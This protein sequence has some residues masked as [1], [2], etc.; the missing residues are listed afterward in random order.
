[1]AVSLKLADAFVDV[2]A[3][4]TRLAGD[5]T[6]VR[7]MLAG[8]GAGGGLAAS[9]V[10]GIAPVGAAVEQA[11][12]TGMA[13]GVAQGAAKAPA[14]MVGLA[15]LQMSGIKLQTDLAAAAAKAQQQAT[16]SAARAP[17]GMVGLNKL[18]MSGIA[19]QDRLTRAREVAA[20]A[21]EKADARSAA[22]AAKAAA[23]A[24]E[25][26]VG[27]GRLQMSGIALQDRL[28]RAREQ[29]DR[30]AA[31]GPAGMVGLEKLQMSGIA[32]QDKLARA[33]EQATAGAAADARRAAADQE[34]DATR[35]DAIQERYLKR[36]YDRRVRY[37]A[38]KQ[39]AVDRSLA[40]MGEGP[41]VERAGLGLGRFL[42][43]GGE[44]GGT[45][46][47]RERGGGFLGGMGQVAGGMLMARGMEAALSAPVR[48]GEAMFDA[49]K[50]ASDLGESVSK[51]NVSFGPAAKDVVGQADML[52]ER[53]GVV[54]RESLDAAA[55]FG[56]MGQAAGQTK[57]ESAAMGNRFVRMG[58][59]I[60]SFH[61]IA[62]AEAFEKL[63]SGLA[64]E[65]E[66]LRQIGILLS[67]DAVQAQ[68][69][70][71]G[72][73]GSASEAKHLTQQQKVSA[74]VELIAAQMGPAM[75]DLERTAG[76][77]A[78][79]LR[80]L[81]GDMENLTT[82]F[83]NELQDALRAGLGLARDLGKA[84]ADA[85]GKGAPKAVGEV[86]KATVDATRTVVQ[87]EG[88]GILTRLNLG[89]AQALSAAF[90]KMGLGENF[91]RVK[92]AADAMQRE[93]E[94]GTAA[95]AGMKLA[96]GPATPEEQVAAMEKS[97]VPAQM[98]RA[99][100]SRAVAAAMA[101]AATEGTPTLVGPPRPIGLGLE[102]PGVGLAREQD[103]IQAEM[104]RREREEAISG[105]MLA[106]GAALARPGAIP[107]VSDFRKK[108]M[109]PGEL[110]EVERRKAM[111]FIARP[112]EETERR[113]SQMF[114]DPADYATHAIQAALSA[115]DDSP[116]QTAEATKRGAVLLQT[117]VD[118]IVPVTKITP[119]LPNS[120]S[121]V[122]TKP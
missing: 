87:G 106:R 25:G 71:M 75:G 13:R 15:K 120:G 30:E 91:G 40:Q 103:R 50:K 48:I 56:L 98:E 115:K 3:D 24:P 55:A 68:A 61:N 57:E 19:L 95:A 11:V 21:Q 114:T 65:I 109:E 105:P 63:R 121:F 100:Q 81:Q 122:F 84:I 1:M 99:A 117:L 27:L 83:G 46:A 4:L 92:E 64:G 111:E 110:A 12:A 51:V 26:M 72:L 96:A 77:A 104:L 94:G 47:G 62:N 23:R 60:A 35:L 7:S 2:R 16:A 59:D 85:T 102:A 112:R 118:A 41:R 38:Q 119:G 88:P 73:V 17:E 8:L 6:K 66:P 54:K 79:Q 113:P 52:A 18:A 20:A 22:Q 58:L 34:R 80:K 89:L 10:R 32:L 67:E 28:A 93:M 86:V 36:D 39:R 76:S 42:G 74:R 101:A 53:F 43:L 44:P 97:G 82:E 107:E 116:K 69:L 31:R 108:F 49:A 37:E 78:N 9:V 5:L 70:K 90:G 29:A 45:T 33:K 14:G